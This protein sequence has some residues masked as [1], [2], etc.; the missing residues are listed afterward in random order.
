[1]V[2]ALVVTPDGLP[3]AYEVLPGNTADC[4]TLRMFLARIEQ[5]YGRARRIWVMDRG[6][7]RLDAVAPR[8]SVAPENY[9]YG[10][11]LTCPDAGASHIALI[12]NGH[13]IE[14]IPNPRRRVN[15]SALIAI[16]CTTLTAW[17]RSRPGSA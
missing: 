13:G 7:D 1:V 10:I 3:L 2:I 9:C 11:E 5:Q 12:G 6:V 4:K 8:I 17:T 15:Y 14:Y 16:G